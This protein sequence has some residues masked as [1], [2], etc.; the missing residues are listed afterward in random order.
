MLAKLP[1]FGWTPCSLGNTES[2]RG[3]WL[4]SEQRSKTGSLSASQPIGRQ[5][6]DRA[7]TKGKDLRGNDVEMI[8]GECKIGRREVGERNVM[9]LR[10]DRRKRTGK[11]ER[12]R[13]KRTRPEDR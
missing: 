7:G 11:R 4:K 5:L 13:G 1:F 10:E 9:G 12:T 2:S 6:I 8:S 3:V